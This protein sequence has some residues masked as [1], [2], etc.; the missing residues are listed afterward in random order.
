MNYQR[1]IFISVGLLIVSLSLSTPLVGHAQSLNPFSEDFRLSVC[2][3][4]KLPS[5]DPVNSLDDAA[6]KA[7][8]GHAKPYVVCDFAG[9]MKQIQHLINAMIILG[10][11][12][13]VVS[14]TVAGAM[15]IWSG[16]DKK[17]DAKKIFEKTFWGLIM[18]LSAWFIVYQLL[19]WLAASPG[20]KTLLGTS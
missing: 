7:Q 2:D 5:T 3:G 19:D 18:M 6:F 20:A 11:L 12:A 14:F 1:N 8:F 17:S 10:V 9:L 4:P 15:L 16:P 13:A